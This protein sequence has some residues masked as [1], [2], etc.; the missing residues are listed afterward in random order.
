MTVSEELGGWPTG[1]GSLVRIAMDVDF[2]CSTAI[3]SGEAA[4]GE[5]EEGVDGTREGPA[6]MWAAAESRHADGD[7]A[8]EEE[9]P[10]SRVRSVGAAVAVS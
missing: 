4:L 2:P 1:T 9:A 6:P 10:E 7:L 3:R 5:E 8:G